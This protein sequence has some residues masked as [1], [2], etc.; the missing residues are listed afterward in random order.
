MHPHGLKYV[1][2]VCFLF[3]HKP[4]GSATLAVV[5]SAGLSP[6]QAAP[7]TRQAVRLS[8]PS[9][10]PE[11]QRQVEMSGTLDRM[12]MRRFFERKDPFS[13]L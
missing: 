11:G 12:A 6:V 13:E 2:K 4:G 1:L 3:F 8:I 10:T 9:R 5:V 7:G